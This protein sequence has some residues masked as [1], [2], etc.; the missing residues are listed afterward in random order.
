V[1][2]QGD[3]ALDAGEGAT[4]GGYTFRFNGVQPL[5][6][7]NFDGVRAR[8]DLLR[9]NSQIDSVAAEKRRYW[10]RREVMTEAGIKTHRGSDL[11]VALGEDL[12]GGRWSLRVQYRP[13]VDLVWISAFIMAL[14]G[15]IATR[16]R[17]YRTVRSEANVI[18]P[19]SPEPSMPAALVREAPRT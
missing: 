3:V 8:I 15:A 1:R 19:V 12:G 18:A 10:V 13:L 17:R 9:G 6:G 5:E 16:D 2:H 11:F 4:L 7:V 14:G